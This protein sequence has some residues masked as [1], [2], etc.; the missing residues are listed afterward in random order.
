MTRVTQGDIARAAGVHNTTV[1]LALRNHPAIPEPTRKRI[2][3]VAEELGYS[4]DPALQ[5]LVA[6]RRGKTPARS[7]E[8]LAYVTGW[9][10]KWGWQDD[11]VQAQYHAGAQ[12]KAVELGFHLEHFWLGE[13]GLT[14]RRLNHVLFHRS[15]RGVFLA[16]HRPDGEP[17]QEI[18]WDQFSAVVIG[19]FPSSPPLHRV[20]DDHAAA[21]RQAFRRIRAAGF[22]RIGLVLP[23]EEDELTEQSWWTSY[24][25]EQSRSA[26]GNRLAAFVYRGAADSASRAF[27]AWYDRYQPE[28][29]ISTL[30]LERSPAHA[31]SVRAPQDAAWVNLRLE[32]N[33]GANAGLLAN[34][35]RVGEIAAEMLVSHVQ[36]NLRGLPSVPTTTLVDSAWAEGESLS[37]L[38]QRQSWQ[39][40]PS[41]SP[42]A[43]DALVIAP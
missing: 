25:A 38:S 21:M 29:I 32:A 39:S 7:H 30:P 28:A 2:Q 34:C 6:Y 26:P 37:P 14:Q 4:P 11:P 13:P 35:G 24:H 43:D 1:S 41:R 16:S 10:T 5:A 23:A 12:R 3:A 19:A 31:A 9:Q 33:D 36:R 42:Y 27:R 40:S 17:L 8:T 20:V 15:I 18:G 22:E